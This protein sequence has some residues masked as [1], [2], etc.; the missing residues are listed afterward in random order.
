LNR[1]RDDH[2]Q[3]HDVESVTIFGSGHRTSQNGGAA[4]PS[5]T[6]AGLRR[7]FAGILRQ[8]RWMIT[9]IVS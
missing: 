3:H 9:D 6:P 2:H 7:T 1:Q 8:S 4:E 5:G